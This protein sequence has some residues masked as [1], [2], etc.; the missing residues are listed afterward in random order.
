VSAEL[1]SA[2]DAHNSYGCILQRR[3]GLARRSAQ[4][5][6]RVAGMR[7]SCARKWRQTPSAS[8]RRARLRA[9]RALRGV[10]ARSRTRPPL[11]CAV[12]LCICGR[13]SQGCSPRGVGTRPSWCAMVLWAL[14][15]Q[16]Q[17]RRACMQL[18]TR[19][20][21]YMRWASSHYQTC[22]HCCRILASAVACNATCLNSPYATVEH[23]G[24][25]VRR[26]CGRPS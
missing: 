10:L 25:P 12:V 6:M 5:Q 11:R 2:C 8:A 23:G 9:A 1:P 16:M 17:Q 26:P 3:F 19:L 22:L 18:L 14:L 20:P 7:T 24:C 4:Q 13:I 21:Q 15:H